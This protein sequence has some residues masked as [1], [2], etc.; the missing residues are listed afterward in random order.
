MIAD[1]PAPPYYAVIFTNIRIDSDDGYAETA[2]LMVEMAERQPGHLG[3]ES[4]RDSS[5][6]GRPGI[7]IS[8]WRDLDSIRAW[9]QVMEHAVAQGRGRRDWYAAYKTRIARVERDYGFERD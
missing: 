2:A 8:Y 6:P 9:K 4:V 3:H 7:T 5:A 1:T